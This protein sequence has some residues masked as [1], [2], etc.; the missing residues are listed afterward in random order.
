MSKIDRPVNVY[1][2]NLCDYEEENFTGLLVQFAYVL[3][4]I[5]FEHWLGG[6]DKSNGGMG[7]SRFG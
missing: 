7:F 4:G 2:G 6:I 3:L 5:I 1:L